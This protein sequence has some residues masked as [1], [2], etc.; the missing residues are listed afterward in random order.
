MEEF[1]EKLY[2][3]LSNTF[4]DNLKAKEIFYFEG[5]NEVDVLKTIMSLKKNNND[6]NNL[7][8]KGA[9]S[10]DEL[11]YFYSNEIIKEC[12]ENKYIIRGNLLNNE[13]IFI[14]TAGM[15]K[16]YSLKNYSITNVFIAFDTNNFQLEKPLTLKSQEKIW[17]IFLLVYGA[18]N[19]Q[20]LFNSEG[21]S[22]EKLKNYHNFL[23]S[24]EKEMEKNSISLGKKIGW[25]TGKDSSFRKFI[26]NIVDLSK[27]PIYNFNG[28][29]YFL[30]LTKRKNVNYLLDLILEKYTG[31]NRLI[32]NEMFYDALRELEF[33]MTMELGEISKGINKLIVEE[34]KG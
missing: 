15:Y 11:K 12:I 17:C 16:F 33:K 14:G 32:V 26:T 8:I 28:Y 24:I 13:K 18:D 5:T 19:E 20:H 7:M 4:V 3:N 31:E 1:L 34:L 23:M 22:H 25:E 10:I 21:L 30:D 2:L 6:L 29:K 27:T 9:I